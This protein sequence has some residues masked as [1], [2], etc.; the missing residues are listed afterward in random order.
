MIILAYVF[1]QTLADG[2]L[3]I[4][5]VL[6]TDNNPGHVRVL[7]IELGRLDGI[8]MHQSIALGARRTFVNVGRQVG[9]ARQGRTCPNHQPIILIGRPILVISFD[10]IDVMEGLVRTAKLILVRAQASTAL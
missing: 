1:Q 8:L 10:A 7:G 9:H 3:S 2:I 6:P 4:I 5:V